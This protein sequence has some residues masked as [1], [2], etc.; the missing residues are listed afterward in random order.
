MTGTRGNLKELMQLVDNEQKREQVNAKFNTELKRV[1]AEIDKNSNLLWPVK[2][3]FEL[4][5][6][7]L[8]RGCRGTRSGTKKEDKD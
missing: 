3:E 5:N 7:N 8:S 4:M 6:K 1:Y 2:D